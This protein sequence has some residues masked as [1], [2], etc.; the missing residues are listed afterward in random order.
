L[1]PLTFAGGEPGLAFVDNA[2]RWLTFDGESERGAGR[3]HVAAERPP[4]ASPAPPS[5]RLERPRPKTLKY[6]QG[7]PVTVRCDGPC[8]LRAYVLDSGRARGVGTATL[9][10]AG[11]T[12]LAI[13]PRLGEHLAPQPGGHARVLVRA[14]A[15]GGDGFSHVSQPAVLRRAPVRPLPRLLDVRAVRDGN[16]ILV[17]WKTDRPFRT[18]SFSVKGRATRHDR[19]GLVETY[20][21]ANGQTSYRVRLH[22]DRHVETLYVIHWVAVTLVRFS[23]PHD[24]RSV[25]VP[26]TG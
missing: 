26:V 19:A 11:R 20:R 2:T 18:G 13:E 12:R 23:P 5:V 8:D 14:W 1:A 15:P 17:T 16:S 9:H 22:P 6:E 4:V 7:M 3:L 24:H 25:V 21:V 10:R